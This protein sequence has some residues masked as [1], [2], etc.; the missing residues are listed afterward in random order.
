MY[1]DKDNMLFENYKIN[2]KCKI[3]TTLYMGILT[4]SM[5]FFGVIENDDVAATIIIRVYLL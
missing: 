1:R 2:Q 5:T 3:R 4:I